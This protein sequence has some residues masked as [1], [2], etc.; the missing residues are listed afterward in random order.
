MR[1][2]FSNVTTLSNKITSIVINN[3]SRKKEK[4]LIV[5]LSWTK[6]NDLSLMV[7]MRSEMILIWRM[8]Y[9]L[10]IKA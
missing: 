10:E 4:G 5:L 7:W 1:T 2:K 6:R 8:L 3:E 9:I